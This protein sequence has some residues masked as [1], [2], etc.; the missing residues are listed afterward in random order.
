MEIHDK[1]WAEQVATE[2]PLQSIHHTLT[3]PDRQEHIIDVFKHFI[4][5]FILN[6]IPYIKTS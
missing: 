2:S 6:I 4:R 1:D 5:L 3:L